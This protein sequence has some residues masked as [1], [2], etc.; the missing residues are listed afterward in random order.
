MISISPQAGQPTVPKLF[1]SIQI[2]GQVP[3]PIGNLARTSTRPYL[4]ENLLRD[5][6]LA[7]VNGLPEKLSLMAEIFNVPLEILAFSSRLV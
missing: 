2:A 6:N 4:N 3:A 5:I 1:P 7:E